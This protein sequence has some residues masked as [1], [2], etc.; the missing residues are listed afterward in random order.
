MIST[1]LEL[2]TGHL[3]RATLNELAGC[4]GAVRAPAGWPA[5][6]I[7]DYLYGVFVTVPDLWASDVAAQAKHMPADLLACLKHAHKQG[8]QLLR[9]DSEGDELD[10]LPVYDE[11][12]VPELAS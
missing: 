8:I 2:S 3:R 1:Y 12:L 4:S 7:A 9:F 5:M 6:T 10:G 11:E